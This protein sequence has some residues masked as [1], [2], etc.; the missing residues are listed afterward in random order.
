MVPALTVFTP[1]FNRAYTLHLCYE[2]LKRQT[3][4]D[5]VWLIID[6]GSTDN[7]RELVEQW[8]SEGSITIIYHYQEN[9]GMHGA[10][11]TAYRLIDTELNVC[12]DSDDYMADDA[13][14]KIINFWNEN[15]NYN[16]AGIIGLD[17]NFN[18]DIIGT[19]M[20]ED[21]KESTL[22]WLYAEHKMRG[23]KKL[24]YRSELTR[25]TPPYPI[26]SGE[27]YCPLSYKYILIDQEYPL[28]IMNEVLCFVEY[29]DDGSSM[30]II[31]QYKKNPRGFSF[32]RKVAMKYAPSLKEKF[33]EAIHY[34]S[35][36]IM[37]KNYKFLNESPCKWITIM[38]I[39]FG[40][41]L[42]LYILNTHKST[43]LKKY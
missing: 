18:G 34:V 36:N 43:V 22:S 23:D 9:Q 4:K 20:P 7:T 38:A 16:Y 33:R 17:A 26:F 39:P 25:N 3:C 11:N 42:Y 2:S 32:F 10:H 14:E 6:D 15:G 19:K 29:L 40:T 37:I 24:V 28:L 8:V 30:N 1:T 35:S 31:K 27:N 5:F 13:V 12:I 41:M 21:V